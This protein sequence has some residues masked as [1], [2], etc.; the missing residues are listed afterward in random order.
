MPA[1]APPPPAGSASATNPVFRDAI[2]AETVR[3]EMKVP[4]INR[5]DVGTG[6]AIRPGRK[7]ILFSDGQLYRIYENYML[8]PSVEK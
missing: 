7:L 3:K 4:Q 1:V 8:T 6:V 2:H 5:V